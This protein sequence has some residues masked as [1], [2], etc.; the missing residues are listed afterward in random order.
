MNFMYKL[1]LTAVVS[2]GFAQVTMPANIK[3][4]DA[5]GKIIPTKKIAVLKKLDDRKQ[6]T[7]TAKDIK[8]DSIVY[9]EVKVK[10]DLARA[11]GLRVPKDRDFTIT[12]VGSEHNKPQKIEQS[13]ALL[14]QRLVINPFGEVLIK[15]SIATVYKP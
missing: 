9:G 10:K 11:R 1:M 3:P 15:E 6:W 7:I 13:N 2:I 4:T 8:K 14:L 5:N 12:I